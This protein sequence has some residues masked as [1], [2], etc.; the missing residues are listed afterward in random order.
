[1]DLAIKQKVHKRPLPDSKS[2]A[3]N[4]PFTMAQAEVTVVLTTSTRVIDRFLSNEV[5]PQEF[6]GL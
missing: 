1:M 4:G 2:S 3:K 6:R 5:M